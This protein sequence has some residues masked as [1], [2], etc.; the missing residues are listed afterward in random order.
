V[1]LVLW[2]VG[3]SYDLHK[4]P[5]SCTED[6][7]C[8]EGSRCYMKFCVSEAPPSK[9]PDTQTDAHCDSDADPIQCYEGEAGSEGAG[10]WRAGMRFCA[11]GKYTR[12]L[13]QVVPTVETCN[14]LDDDCNNVVDDIADQSCQ[15]SGAV[16]GCGVAGAI[17]CRDGAPSCEL[18][19][20]TGV[21]A[22][23]GADDD[24]DG[25]TDE[26]IAGTCFPTGAAGC[27]EQSNGLFA[28]HGVC[29]TGTLSCTDGMEQCTGAITADVEK[30]G[31]SP[32]LDEDCDGLVDENCSCIDGSSQN[33]Y[34]GP[35]AAIADGETGACGPGTQSCKSGTMGP[36]KS[37]S[38]PVP[39]DC[40][41]QGTDDDCNG[42]VDDVKDLETDCTDTTALGVCRVGTLQCRPGSAAPVCVGSDP[43]AE[44]CDAI[45]QDCD[46][47]PVNGFDLN[48][49]QRCGAC[50]VKCTLGQECCGG[51]CVSPMSFNSDPANCGG[52]GMACG[53]YQIC[54]Q[55]NCYNPSWSSYNQPPPDVSCC[56]QNC[57]PMQQCCGSKCIDV[58][59]DDYNCG[60]CGHECP[61]DLWCVHGMCG[62][63]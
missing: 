63:E 57:G 13:D 46:G 54:C 59:N 34:G 31:G 29:V 45:D 7:D 43:T 8:V 25:S 1:W 4:H 10:A 3:C 56:A 33:C 37:Q 17:V 61:A 22:C 20:L 40:A 2:L 60:Q 62:Q 27:E 9:A 24:C 51:K 11:G 6:S 23:N 5:D 53:S 35:L 50:N 52:C 49:N 48:S 36:C 30:C 12:C 44:L 19:Q 55:G 58:K 16:G 28:C 18:T 32:A 15:V 38:L 39:E 26:N 21:E 14:G 42:V 41:N 47:S